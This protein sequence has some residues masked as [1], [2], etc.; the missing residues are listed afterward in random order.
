M[1]D[2][3]SVS[4]FSLTIF[5]YFFILQDDMIAQQAALASAKFGPISKK[6]PLVTQD[7]SSKFS[8]FTIFLTL[9]FLFLQKKKFDSA[10]YFKEHENLKNAAGLGDNTNDNNGQ[11]QVE[12][13]KQ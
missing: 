12:E 11:G 5:T 9:Y 13:E 8:S 4:H 3:D 6:N 10:D 2:S 7:V 1:S